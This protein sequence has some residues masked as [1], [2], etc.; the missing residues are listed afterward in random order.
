MDG[1]HLPLA[2]L[3]LAALPL[4]GRGASA[5]VFLLPDRRALKLLLPGLPASAADREFTAAKV[6]HDAGLPVPAP[7]GRVSLDDR[8]GLVMARIDEP[9]LLRRI[10]RWPGAVMV[11]LAEMAHRQAALHRVTVPT[12]ALPTVHDV[13]AARIDDSAAG[14]LAIAAARAALG[15]LPRGDRLGHGDLHLGN[16]M[17]TR[18]G[19]T[20]VDWAQAMAGDPAADV[21]RSELVMRFGRYGSLL[22]RHG[23][24]RQARGAAAAWYLLCYRRAVGL[25]DAAVDAWRL[26]VAVAWLREGSAAHL[27]SLRAYVERRI[28]HKLVAVGPPQRAPAR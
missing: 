22:R 8:H 20:L 2:S 16:I 27:P 19:I 4:I 1:S 21:A 5:E 13:L 25:S 15:R 12:G 18:A 9:R 23:S 3:D 14:P 11:T 26:P 10:R 24:L 28:G 7:L 6:A 17:T